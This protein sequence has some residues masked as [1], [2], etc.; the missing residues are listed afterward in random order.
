MLQ[1]LGKLPGQ[2]MAL[3]P[4]DLPYCYT[5][6]RKGAASPSAYEHLLFD[7]LRG[8]PTFFARADEVEAAWDI[9]DPVVMQWE[10]KRAPDFPNYAAGSTGPSAA[11]ALL[12]REGRRW[13]VPEQS[14]ATDTGTST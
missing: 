4:I 14:G 3:Q 9:V 8:D 6:V 13:H 11:D 12:T 1:V 10:A 2:A 5:E 7:A